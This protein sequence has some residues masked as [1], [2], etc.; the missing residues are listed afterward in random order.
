MPTPSTLSRVFCPVNPEAAGDEAVKQAC[1]SILNMPGVVGPVINGNTVALGTVDP[2]EKLYIICHG[3][4]DMPV[5]TV[6]KERWTAQ[7]M[8]DLLESSGLKKTHREIVMLVCHAGQ[9]LGDKS[10]IN[11]RLAL[12]ETYDKVRN[13]TSGKDVAKKEK[14]INKFADLKDQASPTTFTHKDQVLPM[15]CQLID[16]LK[17][18]KY[19]FIRMQAFLGP[20]SANLSNGIKVE[21][22]GR[23]EA[24]SP[25]N[26]V[27]WL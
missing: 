23:F 27:N 19:E 1:R 2:M 26:T 10:V 11:Q 14:V 25:S 6:A 3:H 20:V 13:S 16:A 7:Q 5:F 4:Q 9:T 22:H 8:A 12:Q 17:A 18:K 21:V 15:I 24:A